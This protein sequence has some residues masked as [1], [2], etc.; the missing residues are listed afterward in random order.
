LLPSFN[1]LATKNP[2]LASEWH[3]TKNKNLTPSDVMPSS[4]KKVWWLC[5]KCGYEW[6]AT[7]NNRSNKKSACPKCV[8]LIAIKGETDLETTNPNLAKE[9]NYVKNGNLTPQ[10]LKSGS[11][12]IVWWKCSKCGYEWKAEVRQRV[13]G[14][15]K[16]P[17]CAKKQLDFNF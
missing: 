3:P 11:A 6:Q 1:D 15:G 5:K 17:K 7:I 13:K 14:L 12:N 10:K 16:C 9:W 2:E 8:G 4:N